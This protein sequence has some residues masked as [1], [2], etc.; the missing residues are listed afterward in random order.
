MSIAARILLATAS[1]FQELISKY[2]N[3][4]TSCNRQAIE[5]MKK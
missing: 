2:G 5:I 4:H 1:P 3:T